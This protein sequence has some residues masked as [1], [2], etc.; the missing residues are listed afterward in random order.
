M[1]NWYA[2]LVPVVLTLIGGGLLSLIPVTFRLSNRVTLMDDRIQTL[3]K[4]LDEERRRNDA[5]DQRQTNIEV[6]FAKIDGK[7]DQLKEMLERR[8]P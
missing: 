2:I 1:V 5:Q 7:L 8:Q 3:T 6:A 4:G